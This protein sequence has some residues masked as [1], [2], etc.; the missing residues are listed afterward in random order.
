MTS[1]HMEIFVMSYN[2][3]FLMQNCIVHNIYDH[4][5]VNDEVS[6]DEVL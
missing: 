6:N 1:V 5:S 3:N 4:R 2:Y